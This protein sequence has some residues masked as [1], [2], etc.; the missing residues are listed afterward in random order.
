MKIGIDVMGG[1]YAPDATIEGAKL[2]LDKLSSE[3]RIFL[4]GPKEII[5][6]KLKEKNIPPGV[7]TI[8]HSPE[9]IG[10]GKRPIRAYTRKPESS[11]SKGLK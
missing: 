1:D 5:E 3:D 9:I 8:V 4:F 10:M 6:E 11:I 7:F 2:V